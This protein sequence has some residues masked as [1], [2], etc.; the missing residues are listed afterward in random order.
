MPDRDQELAAALDRLTPRLASYPL[1]WEDVLQ[2]AHPRREPRTKTS[3]LRLLSA[4]LAIGIGAVAVGLLLTT[5][6]NG[7]SSIIERAQAALTPAGSVLHLKWQDSYREP[8]IGMHTVTTEIW[9][10]S[11]GR[12]HGFTSDP[13]TGQKVEVG[14]T[15]ELRQSVQYDPATNAIGPGLVTGMFYIFGDPVAYIRNQLRTGRATADGETII[16]ARAVKRIRLRVA[17]PVERN[18]CKT[19]TDDLF[20]DASSYQPVEFRATI[21]LPQRVLLVRRFLSYQRLPTT[22]V[23]LRLTDIRAAHPTA[24]VYPAS[25]YRPGVPACASPPP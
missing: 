24:K 12:W 22:T 6:W 3:S 11:Q 14:G 8:G 15:H 18:E 13:S 20:I 25:P 1:D 19:V 9:L 23:N 17:E 16:D 4:A 10:D 21:F 5:P 2:R 7:G